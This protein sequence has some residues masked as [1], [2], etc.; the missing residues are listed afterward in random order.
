MSDVISDTT[1]TTPRRPPDAIVGARTT[2]LELCPYLRD[3][4]GTWRATQPTGEHRCTAVAPPGAVTAETQ[5]SLCLVAGHVECPVY[6]NAREKRVQG[7]AGAASPEP[8]RPI[9]LTAPVILERPAGAALLAARVRDSLPQ[10]GLILLIA[11]AAG[12]V[13]L[14]RVIAP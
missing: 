10:V 11:L 7:G 13:I 12:A 3:V 1:E 9:P 5:R 14:A 4:T 2:W 8:T 6:Q